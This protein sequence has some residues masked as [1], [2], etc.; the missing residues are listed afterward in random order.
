LKTYIARLESVSPYSQGKFHNEPALEKEGADDYEART[1]RSRAHVDKDGITFI[2]PMALKNCLSE[3]AKYLSVQIPGKGKATYTKHFE[4]GVL[5]CDPMS[6]GIKIEE[7]A[8][9]WLFVPVGGERGGGKR[10]K[11]CF[12]LFNSWKGDLKIHVLDETVTEAVLRIHL[13]AAGSFIG[14][15]TFRPRKNG[16]FGRF[17]LIELVAV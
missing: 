15:G 2:P 7:V 10:V 14:I 12:P 4:A 9:N 16:Y 1:W 13:E 5:I 17:K 3:A 8:G 11:R 6:L